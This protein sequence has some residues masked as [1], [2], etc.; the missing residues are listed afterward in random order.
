M[1]SVIPRKTFM[2]EYNFT[3]FGCCKPVTFPK[4]FLNVFFLGGG[5]GRVG[6]G[7][8]GKFLQNSHEEQFLVTIS[9]NIK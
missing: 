9:E 1:I 3:T 5:G 8:F 2:V 4:K 7:D 6:G